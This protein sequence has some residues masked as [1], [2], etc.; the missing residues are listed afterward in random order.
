MAAVAGL[1]LMV[2]SLW[3]SSA[4][5][6]EVLYLQVAAHW[7]R[8]GEQDR[9]TRVGSPLTFWKLQQGPMLWALDR[10]GYGPWIDNPVLFEA[11]LLPLMRTS[12]LWIWLAALGLIACWSRRLYGPSAMVLASWWFAM[13][14]NLLAHG[15]LVTME[16]PILAAMTAMSLLFWE[17]LRTGNRRALFASAAVGGLA[18]SCKF[19]AAIVPPIFGL[20]WLL[21]RWVDGDRRPARLVLSVVAGM[22]AYLA[23]M[24]FANVIV[25]SGAARPIS[26]HTGTHPSLEGKLGPAE[27]WAVRA[28]ESPIPQDWAGFVRQ[29]ILQRGGTP[30]YLF[31][32]TAATGWRHYYLVTLAVKVPLTFWLVVALRSTLG[33]R[34]PSPGRAWM[35]PAAALAFLAIASL[36]STRNLGY[37]YLLPIAPLAIV[38]ISG[39][40][41][42]PSWARRLAWCGLAGQVL[43]TASIHP[44]ELSYFNAL[45]GGPIGGRRILSD[46]NLDWS[47]GLKPLADLQRAHPEYRDLTLF[48]FGDTEAGRYGVSGRTYA[49]RAESPNA[50]LPGRLAPETTYVGVSASL[51]WGPWG[52]PGFFRALKGV[53]PVCYTPDATIA[54]YRTGDIAGSAYHRGDGHAHAFERRRAPPQ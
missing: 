15:P 51:E 5:Y 45:A 16:L 4:T 26:T 37:R 24:G 22:S 42:G 1:A 3:R 41:E 52:P 54:I 2:D 29:A 28:V 48:F 34:I 17:F 49:V 38:W 10:L 25:T 39:L 36:G 20:I 50:H 43:A 18:F 8:T 30:S 33:R 7:W 27:A 31:G 35:L 19:T 32:Q 40:A 6:D 53:E 47:Q 21:A 12:A 9:I 44:Y 13:S 11:Q 14:P 46:S 23:I